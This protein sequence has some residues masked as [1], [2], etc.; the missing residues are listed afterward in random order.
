VD[1]QDACPADAGKTEPGVCG[2][3]TADTDTDGDRTADCNDACPADAG[4]VDPGVCGCGV[5][6]ADSDGD[7]TADCDDACPA[8]AGKS[9]P[10][11]CGCGT[12]DTDSDGDGTADCNDACPADAGK[13]APGACGCGVS[14][15]AC[16]NR[17]PDLLPP[18]DMAVEEGEAVLLELE[19][20]D[21]DGDALTF[22]ADGLPP[23]LVIDPVTGVVTGAPDPGT[24]GTWV[25]TFSVTDGELNDTETAT[26]TVVAPPAPVDACTRTQGYW[27]N[28]AQAWPVDALTVGRTRLTKAEA[29]ALFNRSPKGDATIILVHQLMAAKLNVAAGASTSAVLDTIAE[30]DAWL[31]RVGLYS[32]P[33]GANK[34]QGI[35]L[36]D[37]LDR[38][39]NGRL[40]P[41]HC[42]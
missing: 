27:K 28:H 34:D 13:V 10:G 18:G 32:K 5:S 9:E 38:F 35:R 30:A 39:N 23:G 2:C 7:R 6:D 19:A 29:L 24:A 42:D 11:V 36:A 14:E 1:C 26:W 8:D 15:D 21:A 16:A 4:K 25:V 22:D 20:V 40:G 41:P 17:A 12:A 31:A 37:V 33:K 3:G